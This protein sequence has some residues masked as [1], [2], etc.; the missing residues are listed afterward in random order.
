MIAVIRRLQRVA[1]LCFADYYGNREQHT[2]DRS[3]RFNR[4]R[5]EHRSGNGQPH[6]QGVRRETYLNGV[7]S[8]KCSILWHKFSFNHGELL[9]CIF[10]NVSH[11][12]FKRTALVE[13]LEY[14]NPKVYTLFV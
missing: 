1:L 5:E 12:L 10:L 8:S 6:H 2:R 9:K 4:S 13:S 14:S 3:P 7:H 11:K